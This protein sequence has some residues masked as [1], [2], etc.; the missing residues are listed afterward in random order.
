MYSFVVRPI[1]FARQC[2]PLRYGSDSNFPKPIFPK[3]LRVQQHPTNL[4]LKHSMIKCMYSRH[5]FKMLHN[6][7]G[8]SCNRVFY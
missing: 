8:N 6:Y 4:S 3:R 7:F 1:Y 2:I 5:V